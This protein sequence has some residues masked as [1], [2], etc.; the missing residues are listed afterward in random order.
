MIVYVH[1]FSICLFL[2]FAQ[3]SD[4]VLHGD[5]LLGKTSDIYI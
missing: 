3:L 1:F 2:H 5:F 4:D